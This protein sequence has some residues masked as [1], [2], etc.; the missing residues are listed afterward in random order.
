MRAAVR[1]ADAIER[2]ED[3]D[4]RRPDWHERFMQTDEDLREAALAFA[5]SLGKA[6]RE[7]LG[8]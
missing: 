6:D 8:R 4:E 2:P 7:R 5:R 3:L 1:H